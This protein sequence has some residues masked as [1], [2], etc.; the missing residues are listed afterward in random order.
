MTDERTERD[1][2]LRV[3]HQGRHSVEMQA[4]LKLCDWLIEDAKERLI[5]C[6]PSMVPVHQARAK[7]MREVKTGVQQGPARGPHT[8]RDR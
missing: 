2:L 1:Q 3:L 8:Q 7:L 6:E 5:S 4:L